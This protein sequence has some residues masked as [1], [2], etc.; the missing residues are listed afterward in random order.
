MKT[1]QLRRRS[2]WIITG[3]LLLAMG[4]T[5]GSLQAAGGGI[6][7]AVIGD[8]KTTILSE[9]DLSVLASLPLPKGWIEGAWLSTDGT[10][11][12]VLTEEGFFRAKT[13]D[14]LT[15]YDLDGLKI[16]AQRELTFNIVLRETAS[17]GASGVLVFKGR[18]A[19]KKEPGIPPTLVGWDARSGTI[20]GSTALDELPDS[21]HLLEAS[22]RVVLAYHGQADNDPAQRVAGR[23]EVFSASSLTRDRV[24][25]LPGPVVDVAADNRSILFA[26]DRG[27]DRKKPEETLPSRVY[28]IDP[29]QDGLVANLEL[30]VGA[31]LLSWDDRREAFYVITHPHKASNAAASFQ[32]IQGSSVVAKIELD[33]EPYGVVPAPDRSQYYV[34]ESKGMTVVSSDL[35]AVLHC[36]A[37]REQPS[38]ILFTESPGRAFVT[39]RDSSRVSAVDLAERKVLADITT[40]RTGKKI[41]LAAAEVLSPTFG[42]YPYTVPDPATSGL[43]SPDG[44]IVFLRN[45]Q[46]VDL[47]AVDTQTL[48]VLEKFPGSMPEIV[49]GGKA[50]AALKVK[51]M[52]LFDLERRMALPEMEVGTGTSEF[53]PSGQYVWTGLGSKTAV[54]D[55]EQHRRVKEYEGVTGRIL[56][57]S[58]PSPE[59]G[60][61]GSEPPAQ[62]IPGSEVRGPGLTLQ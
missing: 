33:C 14:T 32:M 29:A 34:L 61:Q 53:S 52:V 50:L 54:F 28:V 42:P 6:R 2:A 27:T 18:K 1:T 56:F 20:T 19:K 36:I 47:T 26:L 10:R 39:Y 37:L 21:L 59:V 3:A 5:A 11:L 24:V 9:T 7:V 62:A 12:S 8:E 51:D 44:H 43:F 48:E 41:V 45:T 49:L 46:T 23:L 58:A 16:L 57:I 15:I 25:A 31:N 17:D 55:L 13:P 35:S 4:A 38:A 22:G 30:G 60:A 40:G